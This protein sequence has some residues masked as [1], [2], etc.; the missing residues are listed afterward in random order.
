LRHSMARGILRPHF[1]WV[2]PKENRGAP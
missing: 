1:L 2:A